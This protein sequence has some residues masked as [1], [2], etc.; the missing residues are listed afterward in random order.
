[1]NLNIIIENCLLKPT[2]TI[3]FKLN[4]FFK[5]LLCNFVQAAPAASYS[6]ESLSSQVLERIEETL[7]EIERNSLKNIVDEEVLTMLSWY[8]NNMTIIIDQV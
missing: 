4:N 3:I 2:I 7:N 5:Y 1:M 6:N 8:K